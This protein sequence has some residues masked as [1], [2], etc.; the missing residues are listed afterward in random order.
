MAVALAENWRVRLE[1]LVFAR[2]DIAANL[3]ELVVA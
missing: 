1:S 3:D 2:L